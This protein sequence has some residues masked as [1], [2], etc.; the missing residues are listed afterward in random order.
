MLRLSRSQSSSQ[1][2]PL[3]CHCKWDKPLVHSTLCLFCSVY[4]VLSCLD[5][6]SPDVLWDP[7]SA[8]LFH[9]L[10]GTSHQQSHNCSNAPTH[11]NENQYMWFLKKLLCCVSGQQQ[12]KKKKTKQKQKVDVTVSC[13]WHTL[14]IDSNILYFTK[15]FNNSPPPC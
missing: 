5:I 10:W 1:K 9:T 2:A 6:L 8:F 7:S 3:S 11:Q 13:Y 14:V 15:R 12:P 4:K